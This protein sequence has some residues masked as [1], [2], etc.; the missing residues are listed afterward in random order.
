MSLFVPCQ[1]FG[2]YFGSFFGF[3]AGRRNY[4]SFKNRSKT[5][6]AG[7]CRT[8]MFQTTQEKVCRTYSGRV[9]INN[10]ESQQFVVEVVGDAEMLPSTSG[11]HVAFSGNTSWFPYLHPYTFQAV[12][13]PLA[14][15]VSSLRLPTDTSA[16]DMLSSPLLHGHSYVLMSN[17]SYM[18]ALTWGHTQAQHCNKHCTCYNSRR[19]T[20]TVGHFITIIIL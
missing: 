7:C 5:R 18:S 8:L 2:Q 16:S 6:Y 15:T 13:L 17:R 19:I 12:T 14:I 20:I 11:V 9:D 3:A 1:Y 10:A 4:K